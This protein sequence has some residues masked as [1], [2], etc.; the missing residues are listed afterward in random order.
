M[1]HQNLTQ[2][3]EAV[4][5]VQPGEHKRSQS[6]ESYMVANSNR[7]HVSFQDEEESE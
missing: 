7:P 1:K 4:Y 5:N 3:Q 6:L 2:D